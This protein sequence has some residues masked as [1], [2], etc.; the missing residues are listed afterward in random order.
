MLNLNFPALIFIYLPPFLNT[1][2]F[3]LLVFIY[4]DASLALRSAW[5]NHSTTLNSIQKNTFHNGSFATFTYS[6]DNKVDNNFFPEGFKFEID[7]DTCFRQGQDPE[8]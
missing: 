4:N 6:I 8:C 2:A 1:S 3:I 5:V 7:G